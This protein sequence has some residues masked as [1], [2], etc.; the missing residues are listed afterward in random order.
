MRVA[1]GICNTLCLFL[2]F[3]DPMMR[4]VATK[5]AKN[6]LIVDSTHHVVRDI[7]WFAAFLLFTFLIEW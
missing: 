5:Y 7:E 1:F 2:V 4:E 6:G 3:M